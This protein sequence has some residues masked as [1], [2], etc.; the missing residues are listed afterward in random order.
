MTSRD[1]GS[2]YWPM[3]GGAAYR[4]K[5]GNLFT[6]LSG[7]RSNGVGHSN[8]NQI[9][10]GLGRIVYYDDNKGLPT[11]AENDALFELSF[12]L[13]L[14]HESEL[15]SKDFIESYDDRMNPPISLSSEDTLMHFDKNVNIS[16]GGSN[17]LT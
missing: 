8:D 17:D 10:I 2:K 13:G 9:D 11:G 16:F 1:I 3:V 12:S 15:D 6:I 14:F 4:F 5:D 7:D